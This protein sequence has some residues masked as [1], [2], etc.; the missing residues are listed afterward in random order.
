MKRIVFSCALLLVLS[1]MIATARAESFSGTWIITPGD[2]AGQVDLRLQYHRA[3]ALG[4]EE[5]DESGEVPVSD[6]HGLSAA[7]VHANRARKTFTIGQDAGAFRADGTFSGGQGAGTW[8]FEPSAAFR[9]ELRRR[10]VGL[11]SEKQQFQL[12]MGRFKIATLDTLLSS[13][14]ERPS[15]SD[16]VAMSAHGVSDEYVNAMKG[17][18][19]SPKAV[20]ELIRM[21][22][23][24]VTPLYAADMLRRSPQL[25]AKDLVELRDHGVSSEY[26]EA[27]AQ[28][29]YANVSPAQA[30]RMRDH[31]VSPNYIQGMQRL[32]YHESVDDLVRLV[33]HGVTVSF[34]ERMRTHG[35]THLSVDQL[36]R[37]RDHGF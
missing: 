21:R 7:D 25:T 24:G 3:D 20:S 10:G 26:I 11:P 34:I 31:G 27:L 16:L 2:R 35:Y 19:L 37:L 18:R 32:G 12:A 28:G 29:G 8:Q 1:L 22:D 23:H 4:K 30:E 15:V 14:F 36:I 13:G 6:L 17:L 5:W 33:D 9:E